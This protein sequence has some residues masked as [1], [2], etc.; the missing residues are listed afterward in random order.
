[1]D[2][3]ESKRIVSVLAPLVAIYPNWN[4]KS[5]TIDVY[6]AVLADIH[7]DALAAAIMDLISEP[8]DFM[9]TPGVIRHRVIE[10][11]DKASGLPSAYEAWQMAITDLGYHAEDLHSSVIEAVRRIGG[12]NHL[13]MSTNP[14]SERARFIEAYREVVK[15]GQDRRRMLPQVR[16]H[17]ALLAKHQGKLPAPEG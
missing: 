10:L 6:E 11:N 9:P 7:P 16:D 5:E 1:M 13:R 3:N 4:P 15:E 2:P 12:W 17:V 14:A 8:R